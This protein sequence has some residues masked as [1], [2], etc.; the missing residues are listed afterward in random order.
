MLKEKKYS[1]T[2]ARPN[3]RSVLSY[4]FNWPVLFWLLMIAA[5]V[6]L[7]SRH[8]SYRDI[9]GVVE[10]MSQ[11]VSVLESARLKSI[12]VV[13]GQRVC[14]GDVLAHLDTS[15]IDA[16]LAVADA[17]LKESTGSITGFQQN[18]LTMARRFRDA[19]SSAESALET[20]KSLVNAEAAELAELK[21][22]QV[23]RDNL[24]K[25][26]MIDTQT[27][28]ELRPRI[29]SLESKIKTSPEIIKVYERRLQEAKSE[30]EELRQWL[31]LKDEDDLSS[32]IKQKLEAR[33][34]TLKAKRDLLV[35]QK[36][37]FVLRAARDGQVA[38]IQ[39]M[40]G[41]V[42]SR[43]DAVIRLICDDPRYVMGF[44]PEKNLNDIKEGQKV[45]ISRYV[46]NAGLI[47][48]IVENVSP[49]IRSLGNISSAFRSKPVRARTVMIRI[50]GESGLL[51]GEAVRVSCIL[52]KG[53]LMRR[54]T[55]KTEK[56]NG[57]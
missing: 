11:S 15:V 50:Q 49:E 14:T 41:D 10:N 32:A 57:R 19:I 33:M 37:S 18:M 28:Y 1:R 12:D 38:R 16:E 54:L 36:E 7:F 8:Q 56:A 5:T 48:G 21:K 43:G 4:I 20:E 24:L 27:A 39:R 52:E 2:K 9:T 3:Y 31:K 42:I 51:P 23:R 26:K 17:E 45:I 34:V 6:V 35:A 53:F 29:V 40:V 46:S 22:E 55:K 25:K 47:N 44:L 30:N 13:V